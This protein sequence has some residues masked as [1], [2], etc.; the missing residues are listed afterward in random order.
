MTY[1]KCKEE[2]EILGLLKKKHYWRRIKAKI[3]NF[4]DVIEKKID[5][6]FERIDKY[7]N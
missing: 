4:H 2:L 3:F 1:K 5:S 7:L 6:F